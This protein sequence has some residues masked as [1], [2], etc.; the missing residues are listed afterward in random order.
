MS[1][2][3]DL[4]TI[5]G[6]AFTTFTMVGTIGFFVRNL[7]RRLNQAAGLP[8]LNPN[9]RVLQV[10]IP[11][12]A[13]LTFLGMWLITGPAAIGY[14]MTIGGMASTFWIHYFQWHYRRTLT[15]LD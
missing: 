1:D 6:G 15:L 13:F 8:V 9:K 5:S 3:Q 11:L 7:A 14:G 12:A 2:L 4:A 10:I